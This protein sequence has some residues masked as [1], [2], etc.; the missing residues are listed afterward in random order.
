MPATPL[1]NTLV[2]LYVNTSVELTNN[3][4]EE[5]VL[6]ADSDGDTGGNSTDYTTNI[7]KNGNIT[8]T[9]AVQDIKTNPKHY[10]L[11]EKVT[12]SAGGKNKLNLNDEPS[13]PANGNVTHINGRVTGNISDDP[14]SYSI[15]FKVSQIN[16]N[17]QRTW[18]IFTIDPQLRISN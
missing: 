9:G 11:I 8:W 3:N 5:N 17:N 18:N 16:S 12:L 15:T 1:T 2:T 7:T 10:V 14:F 4:I 13:S 6:F